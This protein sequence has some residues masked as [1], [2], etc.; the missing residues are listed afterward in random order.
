M[1]YPENKKI[2]AVK[3]VLE[4]GLEEAEKELGITKAALAIWAY[5]YAA[6]FWSKKEEKYLQD[7][8][9]EEDRNNRLE[10]KCACLEQELSSCKKALK[11]KFPESREDMLAK[12]LSADFNGR[13]RREHEA[14]ME[15]RIRIYRIMLWAMRQEGPVAAILEAVRTPF[16]GSTP[17]EVT[18]YAGAAMQFLSPFLTGQGQA[19]LEDSA[20]VLAQ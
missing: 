5:Q 4:I 19:K 15:E 6:G 2:F 7:L 16:A 12:I 20:P 13:Y 8:K 10:E 11:D 17:E 3:R 14:E 1:S 9:V 18:C